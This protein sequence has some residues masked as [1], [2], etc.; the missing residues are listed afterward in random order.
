MS[1]E[2][3][4]KADAQGG[5]D[6]LFRN[7]LENHQIEPSTG[8]WK[9][10]SR[11]LLR[12]ELARFNFSNLPKTL[13]IGLAGAVL[14]G[15][16]FL[17]YTVP[18]RKTAETATSSPVLKMSPEGK[19]T[20]SLPGTKDV[21]TSGKIPVAK[22]SI[23]TPSTAGSPVQQIR[24]KRESPVL[25]S[26]TT[27]HTAKTGRS[28]YSGTFVSATPA[29]AAAPS[30]IEVKES[31]VSESKQRNTD[32]TKLK[33]MP[34]LSV[35]GLS[36][37]EDEDTLLRFTNLYGITNVPVK[38]KPEISQFYSVNMGISPEYSV[39]RSTDRYASTNYW[40]NAGLTYHIG[41]FSI[42]TGLGLGYVFDHADYRVN[43][44]SKD[45]IGYFTSIISFEVTPG[46]VIVY[47]TKDIPVY[48]SLQHFADDR[49][50][51][52][53][54]YL[55]IPLLV[56]YEL[57]QT[58]RFSL[59][60]KAGPSISFLIGSKEAQPFIDYPN[61]RLIR[62]D[63]NSL[64]R[65]KINWE[66]MAALDLEYRLARNISIY[67]QP[68]YKHY[69]KPFTTDESTTTTPVKDPFAVGIEI[70]ARYNFGRKSTRP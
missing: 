23:A 9:G 50:I 69:F 44:L 63:N 46:N 20:A 68:Y 36:L 17:I 15:M 21:Q 10:I 26:N 55:Q 18:D 37:S 12:A 30:A 4:Y 60:I 1:E 38:T 45:S 64:Q 35:S 31:N 32:N 40:L 19:T 2:Q 7:T 43:Y 13:W 28:N 39:Y 56:G 67:A 5:L 27:N 70:G 33:Y 54:T 66:I 47:T 16:V 51:N 62:V 58:S 61:A 41:R 8:L 53:Y 65:V 52:R 22:G 49:A 29:I 34:V 59:G 14:V 11:K 42:Q 48:D 6:D 24:T 3:K 25:A 57:V